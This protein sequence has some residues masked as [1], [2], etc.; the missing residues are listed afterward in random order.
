M[1]EVMDPT[2]PQPTPPPPSETDL[3]AA[4]NRVLEA[5]PE[6]LTLSKIRA[7]LPAALR[8]V[9]LDELAASL[10]RRVEA[11]VLY[12]Y[13]PYRSQQHRFWDRPMPVHVAALVR[14]SLQEGP[15]SLSQL[16]RKLPDYARGK[17]D[18]VLKDQLDQGLLYQLPK[19][20]SRTGPTLSLQPPD[21]RD[22]LRQ[23]LP[24]LFQRLQA[25]LGFTPAQLREAALELLHEEEW[26][27]P[28]P[29]GAAAAGPPAGEAAWPAGGPPANFREPVAAHSVAA[30]AREEEA[31]DPAAL[32]EDPHQPG[33]HPAPEGQP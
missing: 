5:S 28:R 16:R 23:E 9:N 4:V 13:G 22:P 15:L 3:V 33:P 7:H 25:Q 26:Q 1:T 6:P 31:A 18:D 27:A 11:N 10:R 30:P 32:R 24:R 20:A 14:A 19:G 12:E 17:L 2:S 8:R 21:P 29:A